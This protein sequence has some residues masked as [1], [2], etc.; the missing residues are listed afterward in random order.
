M[1]LIDEDDFMEY[2]G[3]DNTDEEREENVGQIVT[4][5]DFDRQETAYD[6]GKVIEQ[7]EEKILNTSDSQFG[8]NTRL[9]FEKAIEIVKPGGAAND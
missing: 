6:V 5:E 7:L 8:I 9:A 2:L 3:F 4:L 1:R